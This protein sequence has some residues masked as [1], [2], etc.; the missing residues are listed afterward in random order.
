[1][2]LFFNALRC[3]N[4]IWLLNNINGQTTSILNPIDSSS[5]TSMSKNVSFVKPEVKQSSSVHK[6]I[7]SSCESW[8]TSGIIIANSSTNNSTSPFSAFVDM[9]NTL[10]VIDK[11]SNTMRAWLKTGN[12]L[13]LTLKNNDTLSTAFFVTNHGNIFINNDNHS[14]VKRWTSA[15]NYPMIIM[16]INRGC[17]SLFVDVG[18]SLYCSINDGHLVVRMHLDGNYSQIL[19]AAGTGCIG[20]TAMMLNHQSGIYVNTNFDLY[21]ADTRNDRIQRFGYGDLSG[22]TVAGKSSA[23]SVALNNPTSVMLDADDRLYIVDHGNQR[24]IRIGHD[25]IRCLIGCSTKQCASSDQLCHPLTAMFDA[26][27]NIFVINQQQNGIQK[28]SLLINSCEETTVDLKAEPPTTTT[29]PFSTHSCAQ[30]NVVLFPGQSSYNSP[31]QFR[32]S[33]DFYVGASFKVKCDTLFTIQIKWNIFNCTMNCSVPA[34]IDPSIDKTTSELMIPART[35]TYGL[36]ELILTVTMTGKHYSVTKQ[37]VFVKINPTGTT[38]NLVP[39]GTSVITS[40]EERNLVLDP[41]THSID[42]DENSFNASD[43]TYSY[44]CRVYDTKNLKPLTT[45]DNSI[46]HPCFFNRKDKHPGWQD[47][48][49]DGSLSSITI[50]S[51]SLKADHTFQFVVYITNLRNATLRALGYLLVKVEITRPSMI[52]VACVISSMCSP[53]QEYQYINPSTQVALFSEYVGQSHTL[54][55][56]SWTIHQGQNDSSTNIVRWSRFNHLSSSQKLFY[57][58]NTSNFT[59]INT[60]FLQNP[61]I[62]YWRFEVTYTFSNE[63]SM[64][65]LNFIINQPPQNGSCSITPPN[66]TITT[67]FTVNCSDWHDDDEIKDYSVYVKSLTGNSSE[68]IMLAFKPAS[69]IELQLPVGTGPHSFLNLTV[70]IRDRLNCARE[71]QLKPVAVTADSAAIDTFMNIVQNLDNINTSSPIIEALTSGDQSL[72]G[73]VV[74]SLAQEFNKKSKQDLENAIADGTDATSISISPLGSQR[75]SNSS[76]VTKNNTTVIDYAERL[77]TLAGVRDYLMKC[78]AS[79]AILNVNSVKLLAASLAQVTQTTNELTRTSSLLGAQKCHQ[80]AVELHKRARTTPYEDARSAVVQI[81]HCINNIVTAVNAPLQQRGVFLNDSSTHENIGSDEYEDDLELNDLILNSIKDG[82]EES[83]KTSIRTLYYQRKTANQVAELARTTLSLLTSSLK[84]HVNVEQQL[85]VNSPS[86]LMSLETI[87]VDSLAGKLIQLTDNAPIYMPKNIQI[88]LPKDT[89]VSLRA[90]IQ[91]LAP[92][93]TSTSHANSNMSTAMS[94]TLFQSNNVEVPFT[95]SSDQPIEFFIPRD[96]NLLIPPLIAQNITSN[97]TFHYIDL[98]KYVTNSNLTVSL[99]FEVQPMDLNLSYL[100][101]YRFEQS[102]PTSVNRRWSTLCPLNVTNE[103]IHTYFLDN[104]QTAGQQSLIFR[105]EEL[106]RT[107]FQQCEQYRTKQNTF[108]SNALKNLTSDYKLRIYSSGCYYLDKHNNWQSDGLWVGPLTDHYRT[109]CYSTHL[110]TF[111]SHFRMLSFGNYWKEGA[112]YNR[113][114]LT[115]FNETKTT[116]DQTWANCSS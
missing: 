35:L 39:Y 31:L 9:N 27:G 44:Q 77:N 108:T 4:I 64:S 109:Q 22:T 18:N 14:H 24:I 46:G 19:P 15:S 97:F 98:N 101:I 95:T 58:M 66:G 103:N 89:S 34:N 28:Y 65:A 20:L 48:S 62:I 8:N 23:S 113:R 51:G 76:S 110:T 115:L 54:S 94:L 25:G 96:Q 26:H 73:S 61:E 75:S 114:N 88:N 33:Q 42:L 1:M 55:S 17:N 74:T 41:G 72:V 70:Q 32:R 40:G 63:A 107:D 16:Y 30:P 79:L 43:W 100:F 57:G 5:G 2:R 69:H 82:D 99:H 12:E 7:I 104:R 68:Q 92:I 86:L 102:Y 106:N 47:S 78:T 90:T 6:P 67:V 84:I 81:S 45:I 11:I 93:G 49:T 85:Q 56:I 83:V 105:F 91:P 53:N 87:T 13:K 60:L 29:K 37:S 21:V 3:F 52:A 71:V 116:L 80:L 59:A 38:A 36:Y 111:T 50:L 112:F 10:Y